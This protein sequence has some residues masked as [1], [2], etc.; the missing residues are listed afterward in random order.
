MAISA[1]IEN[2]EYSYTVTAEDEEDVPV[3]VLNVMVDNVKVIDSKGNKISKVLLLNS[4]FSIVFAVFSLIFH[5][6]FILPVS[7]LDSI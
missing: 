3:F 1:A 2:I 6:T 7:F 4:T 5:N